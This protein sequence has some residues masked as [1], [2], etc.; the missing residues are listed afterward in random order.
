[1]GRHKDCQMQ[2]KDKHVSQKHLRVF[3]NGEHFYLEAVFDGFEAF[4]GRFR[5]AFPLFA[6]FSPGF[7]D[8]FEVFLGVASHRSWG[9]RAASSA[10]RS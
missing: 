6:A 7:L 4:L 1:M 5:H 9:S 3:R 8:R 2:A 10:R